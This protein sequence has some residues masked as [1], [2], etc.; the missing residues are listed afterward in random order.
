MKSTC[1]NVVRNE[2]KPFVT[3]SWI[4]LKIALLIICVTGSDWSKHSEHMAYKMMKQ[5]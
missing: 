4:A 2:Q 5:E 1:L 3:E